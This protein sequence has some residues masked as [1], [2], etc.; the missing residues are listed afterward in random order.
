MFQSLLANHYKLILSIS[1][2][3]LGAFGLYNWGYSAAEQ[4]YE[5]EIAK[6]QERILQL[7]NVEVKIEKEILT[8]YKD[9]I[10]TV[11]KV[12]DRIIEVTPNVLREESMRCS[13]G[14]AFISLH[15][16]AA[17]NQAVSESSSRVDD[18]STTAGPA[19]Q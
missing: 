19:T 15:N 10:K 11:D 16:A 17:S 7:Q 13:I 1:A 5:I 6:Q 14:S 8:V 3:L 12:R 18:S 9:R 2:L 4:K